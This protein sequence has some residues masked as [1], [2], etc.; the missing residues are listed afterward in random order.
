MACINNITEYLEEIRTMLNKETDGCCK[1]IITYD[2]EYF[3]EESSDFEI[4]FDDSHES[5][6]IDGYLGL[7]DNINI[8][9]LINLSTSMAIALIRM[10]TLKDIVADPVATVMDNIANDIRSKQ[11]SFFRC[12]NGLRR[13]YIRKI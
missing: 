2:D 3:E 9:R 12:S 5:G 7:S 13:S 8:S 10:H 6:K 1:L 4:E 11:V